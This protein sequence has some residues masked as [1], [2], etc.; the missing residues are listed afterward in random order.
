MATRTRR[1]G[2]G[3]LTSEREAKG[4]YMS[5]EA[6]QAFSALVV[7]A[8]LEDLSSSSAC[9]VLYKTF[10]MDLIDFNSPLVLQLCLVVVVLRCWLVQ[11]VVKVG[12]LCRQL[13]LLSKNR[14]SNS[15]LASSS[16]LLNGRNHLCPGVEV[17]LFVCDCL[18]TRLHHI[19]YPLT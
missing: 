18:A 8:R 14:P 5:T 13:G 4:R 17:L 16:K 2:S 7:A 9:Q 1:F 15:G 11:F 3:G 10:R 12:I 6:V 19:I